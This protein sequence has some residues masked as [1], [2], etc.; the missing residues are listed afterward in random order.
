[1]TVGQFIKEEREKAGLSIRQLSKL[2]GVSLSYLSEVERDLKNPSAKIIM[3]LSET[4]NVSVP[5]ENILA[6]EISVKIE[7]N[8]H[9][10]FS[11]CEIKTIL[12]ICKIRDVDLITYLTECVLIQT[13][14]DA[15]EY[16]IFER[17]PW[18]KC[19]EIRF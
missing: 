5:I 15:K 18:L 7:K 10:F 6:H 11:D 8:L 3:K 12:E 16:G 14:K 1:M 4:L 19:G 13:S 2:S 9:N 17:N